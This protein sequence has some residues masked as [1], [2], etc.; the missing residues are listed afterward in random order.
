MIDRIDSWTLWGT[1]A[2][3]LCAGCSKAPDEAARPADAVAQVGTHLIVQSDLEREAAWRQAQGLSR[4][5]PR[6]LL[7]RMMLRAALLQRSERLRLSDDPEIRRA[8]D[9]VLLTHL[10]EQELGARLEAVRITDEALRAAYEEQIDR[11]RKPALHRVAMLYV[12]KDKLLSAEKRAA[13]SAR[14]EE[15]HAAAVQW[16]RSPEGSQ[17]L[18]FGPVARQY[19]DDVLGRYRGGDLGWFHAAQASATIPTEVFAQAQRLAVG[20]LS[21]VIELDSGFY[22]VMRTDE[23]PASV[24]PFERVASQ[25]R[26][27]L[28]RA[29][30]EEVQKDYEDALLREVGTHVFDPSLL[31]E[32]EMSHER[33]LQP[34]PPQLPCKK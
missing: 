9:R 23:R 19:S 8:L 30:R 24:L 28:L 10:R 25:L 22:V 2:L 27:R 32:V 6:D 14:A 3:A 12:A 34:E 26:A 16:L 5:A 29:R 13:L 17:K 20:A 18:G 4:L 15:A 21:D 1:L 7:D 33:S 31:A 11:Y